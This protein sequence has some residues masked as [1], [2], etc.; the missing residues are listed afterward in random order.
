[1]SP[2]GVNGGSKNLAKHYAPFQEFGGLRHDPGVPILF[3]T[4]I[5][6]ITTLEAIGRDHESRH[7]SKQ[8]QAPLYLKR[9]VS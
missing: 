5:D 9:L 1:M 2:F 3:T 6:R 7:H 4:K 8:I